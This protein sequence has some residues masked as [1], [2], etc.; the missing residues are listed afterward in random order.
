MDK[1]NSEHR[2][3]EYELVVYGG[4]RTRSDSVQFAVTRS[5]LVHAGRR[6]DRTL[7]IGIVQ[8]LDH[9]LFGLVSPLE[10]LKQGHLLT[11][12]LF[13]HILALSCIFNAPFDS[14]GVVSLAH[15]NRLAA[16]RG[17]I[18]KTLRLHLLFSLISSLLLNQVLCLALSNELIDLISLV[19][20]LG[21]NTV[22]FTLDF[23]SYASNQSSMLGSLLIELGSVEC[24]NSY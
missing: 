24:L 5:T 2:L 19:P 21:I 15:F 20:Y 12:Q 17:Y 9:L 11:F 4:R 10:S 16:H 6:P 13:R 1:V 18:S 3:L 7:L 22:V 8:L 23:I 14:L